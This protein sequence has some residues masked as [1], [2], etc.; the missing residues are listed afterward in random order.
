MCDVTAD[1]IYRK[2]YF[3]YRNK[4]KYILQPW[5]INSST[6]LSLVCLSPSK[7]RCELLTYLSETTINTIIQMV[8]NLMQE[9][10]SHKRFYSKH[11][12]IHVALTQDNIWFISLALLLNW[13]NFL[14]FRR[15]C[16]R[17]HRVFFILKTLKAD[18]FV[19]FKKCIML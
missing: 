8:N 14:E 9:R 15:N 11:Y 3:L 5:L 4:T 10:I 18:T 6:T 7:V 2:N 19:A 17:F 12:A 16:G 1:R 13:P